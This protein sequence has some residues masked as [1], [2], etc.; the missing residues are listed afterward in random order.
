MKSKEYKVKNMPTTKGRT[1][2]ENNK[3]YFGYNDKRKH[4]AYV[5]DS[6]GDYR[7]NILISTKPTRTIKRNGKSKVFN[8]IELDRHPNPKYK[9][10]NK[11]DKV[12][13]M[14]R[15]YRDYKGN[16]KIRKGWKFANTDISKVNKI[17]TKK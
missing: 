4:Y 15:K 7:N 6:D 14:T 5:Y 8:N 13:L 16:I 9:P 10:K 1:I 17:I 12:Y 2:E 11:N 3:N